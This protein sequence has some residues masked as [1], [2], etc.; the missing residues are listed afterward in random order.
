MENNNTD[1]LEGH[2]TD[3]CACDPVSR[4]GNY[5]IDDVLECHCAEVECDGGHNLKVYNLN[6]ILSRDDQ[7]MS[8]LCAPSGI[9]AKMYWLFLYHV[10]QSFSVFTF[11]NVASRSGHL[12]L[13]TLQ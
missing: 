5:S 12:Y 7:L 1:I 2:V 11:P 9:G 10:N 6:T 8:T 3:G 13:L 4:S